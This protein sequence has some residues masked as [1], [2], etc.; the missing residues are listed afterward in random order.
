VARYIFSFV[1]SYRSI[2]TCKI[3]SGR[4]V[5]FW[6]DFWVQGQNLCD[7]YPRIFSYA[8]DEDITIQSFIS[9][10]SLESVF[11]L[12]LSNQTFEELQQVQSISADLQLSDEDQDVRSFPW[13]ISVHGFQVLQI[14]FPASTKGSSYQFY[15]EF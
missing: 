2:T 8:L 10:P 9:A 14:Y 11:T 6:K 15:L 1:H 5:L 3:G 12:P 13:F 4:S 7:V